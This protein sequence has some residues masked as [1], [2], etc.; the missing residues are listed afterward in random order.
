MPYRRA[1]VPTLALLAGIAAAAETPAP[2]GD[3][4]VVVG[5]TQGD[6]QRLPGTATV[7]DPDLLDVHHYDSIHQILR[8]VPGATVVD[9]D[10]Y[11]VRANIGMRG[12]NPIRSNKVH[13]MEDGVPI[14]PNPY[15]DPSLYV[16]PAYARFTAIEVLKGSSQILYGPHTVAGAVNF[17]TEPLA[18]AS[19]GSF[20]VAYG[21]HDTS[22]GRVM[23][24]VPLGDGLTAAIDAYAMDTSGFR[25]HDD[26]NL[27]E[28]VGR[29]GW[30]PADGHRIE[31]KLFSGVE[32][33]NLTYIGQSR[34]DY[35]RDAYGR[36]DFSAGDTM[37]ASRRGVHLRHRWEIGETASLTSTLYHQEV[38][39]GWNR[40]EFLFNG[41][42]YVGTTRT[43][44]GFT[45][46]RSERA[47]SYWSQGAEVRYHDVVGSAV[48]LTI[49][50]GARLHREGQTNRNIDRQATTGVL[51]VRDSIDR[52]SQALAGW[53]QV[54][55]ELAD[56]LH[57]IPGL[58][59]EHIGIT[60]QRTVNAYAQTADPEGTSSTSE[61]LPGIGMTW[62]LGG[63]VQLYGGVHRGFS[64]PSYSQAVASDGTDQE[65]DAETSW[66]YEIGVRIDRGA[67][68]SLDVTGFYVAWDNIIAQGIAG[69]PQING[70]ESTHYGVEA[71][72]AS[73][74]G[75]AGGLPFS[76]PLR[77][78][79]AHVTARYDADIY[80]GST[81]VAKSGNDREFSPDLTLSAS[82]GIAGIGPRSGFHANLTATH[83][84]AQ[85]S[86]GMNTDALSADGSVGRIDAVTL[87]DLTVGWK[88]A[89]A[90]Y[91]VYLTGRNIADTEYV[92]Y[93]RGGHGSVAGA[94]LTAMVG[95]AASF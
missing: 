10:G 82:L 81:L 79:A 50:T 34:A 64:P 61:L 84:G 3:T 58:R 5:A 59:V 90:S 37:E 70:G 77:V 8:L 6:S 39:R 38:D 53:G 27:Q 75:R 62:A 83:V 85:Y 69:G 35:E 45:R 31:A 73:D 2:P 92:A 21:S 42:T 20:D 22:R 78:A 89:D 91:E 12:V 13:V 54:D 26:V 40:A 30:R 11:G 46:D 24:E 43:T 72:L 16:G 60:S 48:P 51:A 25:P 57:V 95:L 94:P 41:T 93:R 52:E 36:Y 23:I 71:L 14:A 29:I 32:N 74:L 19:R 1:C 33:S 86:D 88:P 28:L 4:L 44:A 17:K 56:G 65:L 49:D 87:L 55:A 76:I 66:N 7:L 18:Y 15:N 80:S 9:E 68:F 63:G 67:P 47:R